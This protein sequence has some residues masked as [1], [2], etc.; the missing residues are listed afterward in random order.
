[1][2]GI[3]RKQIYA[4]IFGSENSL[5]M[6]KKSDHLEQISANNRNNRKIQS[7]NTKKLAKNRK[8]NVEVVNI[9]L[10]I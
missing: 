1:M 10:C 5:L 7:Q 9:I 8:K 3:I 4:N 6:I 2:F